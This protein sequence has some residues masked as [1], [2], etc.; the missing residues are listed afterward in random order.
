MKST[1]RLTAVSLIV[2][3]MAGVSFGVTLP[4]TDSFE[5]ATSPLD[6]WATNGTGDVSIDT[7]D[8]T[9]GVAGGAKS[10]VISNDAITVAV[11]DAYNVWAQVYTKA[12]GYDGDPADIQIN[13]LAAVFFITKNGDVRV[14]DGNG[15]DGGTWTNVA[16]LGALTG[17]K[18]GWEGFVVHLDY[19]SDTWELYRQTSGES[20]AATLTRIATDL[21]FR[22]D[23]AGMSS[24]EV[25]SELTASVDTIGLIKGYSDVGNSTYS[26]VISTT[27]D[28][29]TEMT[30]MIIGDIDHYDSTS[31]LL[32]DEAGGDLMM[33][34]VN[35]DKI[36]L[37]LADGF[38]TFTY[39]GAGAWTPGDVVHLSKGQSW[40]RE[41]VTT[42][43]SNLE[44]MAVGFNATGEDTPDMIGETINL[45]GDTDS[46]AAADG[47][48]HTVY[49]GTSMAANSSGLPDNLPADTIVYVALPDQGFR[50]FFVRSGSLYDYNGNPAGFNLL[51]GSQ[52]WVRNLE[53]DAD[54]VIQ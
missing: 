53:N 42:S 41:Y 43:T 10:C 46:G 24:I 2:G 17:N 16:S 48:S 15:S 31:D 21:G 1:M 33:G 18:T 32:S 19:D 38:S 35:G 29:T 28:H 11:T 25:S 14:M 7:V 52:V 45:W 5:G 26:N 49:G 23:S 6:N 27:E 12:A 36:Q 34:M 47:W 9:P 54:W 44:F 22:F 13:G 37:Y 3:L 39:N 51:N 50:A 30:S 8:H 4:F 40:W 20:G